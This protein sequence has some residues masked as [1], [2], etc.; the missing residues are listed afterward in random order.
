[1]G[2]NFLVTSYGRTATF[3]IAR[4]LDLHSDITCNHGPSI[5]P[6]SFEYHHNKVD[7]MANLVIHR[8]KDE[9]YKSPASEV[10][11]VLRNVKDT[12]Y[13]GNVHGYNAYAA[14]K[15]IGRAHV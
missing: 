1:M 12:P 6:E 8:Q 9:F 13:C 10:F 2:N 5:A 11:R 14:Y 15:E 7:D 4:N 3:W